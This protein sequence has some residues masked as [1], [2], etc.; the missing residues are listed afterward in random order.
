MLVKS[1]LMHVEER[2]KNFI[3][4]SEVWA[5]CDWSGE[6]SWSTDG[7]LNQS[8]DLGAVVV[9]NVSSIFWI[10]KK[11]NNKTASSNVL[12]YPQESFS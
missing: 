6:R 4:A 7:Q 5:I 3:Y 2:N 10:I 11:G 1:K 8:V 12:L 9:N